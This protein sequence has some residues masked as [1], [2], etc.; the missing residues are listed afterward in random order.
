ME[1]ESHEEKLHNM[2]KVSTL[3]YYALIDG[4]HR[5]ITLVEQDGDGQGHGQHRRQNHPR[6]PEPR[7]GPHRHGQRAAG[8]APRVT[9]EL[10]E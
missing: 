1:M 3:I 4:T 2:I 6:G 7:Q 5:D 10:S 9:Q 8:V